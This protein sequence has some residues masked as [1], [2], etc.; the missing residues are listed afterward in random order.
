MW[1]LAARM[2]KIKQKEDGIT[3]QKIRKKIDKNRKIRI[4]N[5]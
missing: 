4:K 5:R 2:I 1:S 3:C